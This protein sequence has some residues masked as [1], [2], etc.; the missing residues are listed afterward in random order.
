MSAVQAGMR[1]APVAPEPAAP[2]PA[3][4]EPAAHETMEAPNRSR[5]RG[6]FASVSLSSGSYTWGFHQ[7]PLVHRLAARDINR[8]IRHVIFCDRHSG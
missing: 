6:F 8:L 3:T 5:G 4:P 2:E 1:A 7:N